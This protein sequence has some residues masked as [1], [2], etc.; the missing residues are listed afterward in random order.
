MEIHFTSTVFKEGR[1]FVAHTPELDVSMCGA[2]QQKA[3]KNLKEAVRLFFE[4]AGKT[5]ALERILEE[6][7]YLRR[8]RGKIE[9]PRFISTQRLSIPLPLEHAK[10]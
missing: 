8:S 3:L 6:A 5:G 4:E 9:G 2:T 1:M 10:A 7:G